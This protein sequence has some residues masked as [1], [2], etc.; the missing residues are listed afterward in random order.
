MC[1][2][3]KASICTWHIRLSFLPKGQGW[4]DYYFFFSFDFNNSKAMCYQAV[5]FCVLNLRQI[6]RFVCGSLFLYLHRATKIKVCN[7]YG[8]FLPFTFGRL[9][10]QQQPPFPGPVS[11]SWH[12]SGESMLLL[13]AFAAGRVLPAVLSKALHPAWSIS[14]SDTRMMREIQVLSQVLS[15]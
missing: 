1:K 12:G 4:K 14:S 15:I 3:A 6:L 5:M 11:W 8:A 10:K 7:L 13:D 2:R 9:G